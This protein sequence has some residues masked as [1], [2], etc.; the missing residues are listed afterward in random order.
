MDI[1][2]YGTS[3]DT[4]VNSSTIINSCSNS[5]SDKI[6]TSG[7]FFFLFNIYFYYLIL[8]LAG[9][10]YNSLLPQCDDK[11]T[12]LLNT[13]TVSNTGVDIV[14]CYSNSE[15]HCGYF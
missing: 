15:V 9:S 5:N 7:F 13:L 1:G 2:L 3:P 10:A 8:N 14:T 11:L 12:S 6:K 4:L